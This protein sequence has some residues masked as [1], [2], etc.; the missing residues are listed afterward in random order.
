M[1]ECLDDIVVL[2]NTCAGDPASGVIS[3][4]A[5]G[6]T[7]EFLGSITDGEQTPEQ[8]LADIRSH[9]RPYIYNDAINALNASVVTSTLLDNK[10][11]GHPSE[12]DGLISADVNTRGGILL[13]INHPG[14]NTVVRITEARFYGN[15][16]GPVV[17]TV[18]DL[19]DGSTVEAFTITAVAGKGTAIPLNLSLPA[20]RERK[21]YLI[22]H[23][24]Q[25]FRE[26]YPTG[27]ASCRSGCTDEAFHLSGVYATG[28]RISTASSMR[29]SNVQRTGQTS[30]LSIIAS[31]ACDHG[32]WLCE[33]RAIMAL[34]YLNLLGIGVMRAAL[35]QVE[36]MNNTTYNREVL[37]NR[38]KEYAE[39]YKQTMETAV[40][41]LPVGI[42]PV[43]FSC[44]QVTYNRVGIP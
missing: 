1:L 39:E 19:F 25:T 35:A 21:R 22:S 24:Q 17:F 11:I 9:A 33:N 42:D 31:L 36:R 32:Q 41:N 23:D 12:V 15:V 4:N 20:Y 43:C 37:E 44:R 26:L 29:N 7:E 38:A 16:D 5:L 27:D 18:Y 6:I 34:P 10:R 8:L 3:L 28:A 13:E 40:K 30:G 14:S 2:R